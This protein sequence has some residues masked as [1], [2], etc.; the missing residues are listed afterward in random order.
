MA[1]RPL[2][3]VVD[4]SGIGSV[5]RVIGATCVIAL[6]TFATAHI[7]AHGFMYHWG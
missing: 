5:M 1:Q 2:G 7:T 6:V 4:V 3:V